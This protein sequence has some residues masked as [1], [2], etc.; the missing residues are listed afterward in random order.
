MTININLVRHRLDLILD[1]LSE[2]KPLESVDYEEFLRDRYKQLAAE[3]LIE[4]IIQAAI[5]INKHLLKQVSQSVAKSNADAFGVMSELGIIQLGL[6]Q[7]LAE[8][9]KLRNR[10]THRYDEI[11][12]EMIFS[13]IS[14][15]LTDYPQYVEQIADF[16]DV[17]EVD[18][19]SCRTN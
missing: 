11:D 7:K 12:P 5:D 6:A 1:Y 19:D 2:L 10:L 8:S 9:G 3:R 18:D 17:L 16:I 4:I 14:Q 13:F 15:I